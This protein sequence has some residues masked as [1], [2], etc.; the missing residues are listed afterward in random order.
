MMMIMMMMA[1]KGANQD[2]LQSP[3]CATNCLHHVLSSDQRTIMCKSH[4][5]GCVPRCMKAQLS[6]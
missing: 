3:H 5:A 1:L 4:A 2:F 6:F